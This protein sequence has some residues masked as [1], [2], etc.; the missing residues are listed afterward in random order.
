[1]LS[2]AQLALNV[3]CHRAA[4]LAILLGE[5]AGALD[6]EALA[7]LDPPPVDPTELRHAALATKL[8]GT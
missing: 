6:Y 3:D 5:A 2:A 8:S 4:T 7:A 1:M